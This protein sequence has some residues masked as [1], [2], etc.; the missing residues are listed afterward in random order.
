MLKLKAVVYTVVENRRENDR[1]SFKEVEF[2][3]NEVESIKDIV[4]QSEAVLTKQLLAN[5]YSDF[6]ELKD[7]LCPSVGFY[8]GVSK[9]S[10]EEFTFEWTAESSRYIF[11]FLVGYQLEDIKD[12][13]IST[14][15]YSMEH[16][17]CRNLSEKVIFNTHIIKNNKLRTFDSFLK[18]ES[19][20]FIDNLLKQTIVSVKE[21]MSISRFKNIYINKNNVL[22]IVYSTDDN[23]YLKIE[24]TKIQ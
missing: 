1:M 13:A 4:V 21:C 11:R 24:I 10:K 16:S 17:V 2:T 9:N 18:K 19:F 14:K 8:K 3:L 22:V 7:T 23:E 15:L 12:I 5:Y 20:Q 6:E